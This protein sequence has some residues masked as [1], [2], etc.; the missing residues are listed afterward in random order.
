MKKYLSVVIPVFNEQQHLT[1]LH[2]RLTGTLKGLNK[3]YEIIYVDDGS[4]DNSY[5]IL[6]GFYGEG[7]S[8]KVIRLSRNF[9]QHPAVVAGFRFAKGEIIVTLDADL[10]NPPEEIPVLVQKSEEGYGVVAGW[11]VDRKDSSRRRFLSRIGNVLVSRLTGIKLHDYGCMMRAYKYE[12]V[13]QV[14]LCPEKYKTITALIAWL[15]PSS[16]VEV[17]IKHDPREHGRSNYKMYDLF[18][19][20]LGLI[21][22]YSTTPIQFISLFGMGL[23]SI[24]FCASVFLSV[25]YFFWNVPV[26]LYFAGCS[27]F[28]FF[29]GM[30]MLAIGLVGE[31]VGR[32][33]VEVQ[34]R[35]YFI[36]KSILE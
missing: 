25:Q 1:A 22:G 9:G 34:G 6:K 31:Y 28:L 30:L 21:V 27:A 10:Q 33:F 7:K 2:E 18:R 26:P 32:I 13:Q 24:G 16:I 8:V 3:P 35:P 4:V 20:A 12:T 29:Y 11:R 19:L 23:A 14:L 17:K 36:M 15:S 5:E